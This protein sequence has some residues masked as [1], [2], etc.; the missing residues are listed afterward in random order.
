[1]KTLY[2]AS[3]VYNITALKPMISNHGTPL[4]YFSDRRE[5]VLVYLSN[6][7]ERYCT[8]MGFNYNGIWHKWGPYGF[9][10]DG[11]LQ[12]QE[13]YPN[14]LKETYLG[15]KGCIY[16]VIENKSVTAM[17]D[18]PHAYISSEPVSVNCCEI[19]ED[20]YSEIIKEYKRGS[21]DILSYDNLSDKMHQWIKITIKKEYDDNLSHPEYRYFLKNKFTFL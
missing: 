10:D 8:N 17:T 3:S 5:N 11:R 2:H 20:A 6:A 1:M 19:I 18:I 12:L 13:Y 7:V 14:A 16:S 4:V 15:V 21:I 9:T